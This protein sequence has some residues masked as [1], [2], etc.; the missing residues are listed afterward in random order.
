MPVSSNVRRMYNDLLK[1]TLSNRRST[2]LLTC[3]F[4]TIVIFVWYHPA[5]GSSASTT[6]LSS[7]SQWSG[8]SDVQNKKDLFN[9]TWDYERDRNNLLL[10]SA[11]CEQA[12]PG[13]FT[14]VDRAV[15]EWQ[16]RSI[17]VADVD[18]ITPKN[19]YVRAM[20]YDQELYMIATQGKIYS[21]ELATLHALH[22]AIVSSP[23]PLPNI[24]F[25][26]NTDDRIFEPVPLWGYARQEADAHIWLMPD[27]GYWSWPETKVG[28][29]REV[30]MKAALT[31]NKWSWGNKVDKLLWRGATMGLKLR[32]KLIEAARDKPWADVKALNWKDKD[33]VSNDL[34]SMPEHCQYKY[35]AHTEGNSYSGRLKYLQSCKS[36]IVAHEMDWIQHHHP[37]MRAKGPD[38][39]YVQVDRD[40]ERLSEQIEWLQAHDEEAERI[41]TNSVNTFR[42]RYLTPAAETC[43]WRRLIHGWSHVSFQPEFFKEEAGQKVWRGLPFESFALERRLEWDPY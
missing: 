9:G 5:S 29:M 23:E 31:E 18:A 19:G 4:L 20:I 10:D 40:Y 36:V 6:P 12:F 8:N 27:F 21:R 33:S 28:T 38:Q 16:H 39:N 13:L 24:E 3:V 2:I 25:A 22:R 30:Q 11:Q 7:S 43:Y 26:F 41:A 34:K 35:L 37:L 42:Y 32:E 15:K 1:A 14:E 17:S